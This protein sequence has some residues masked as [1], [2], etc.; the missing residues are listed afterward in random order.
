MSTRA[1][2]HT[3]D[4]NSVFEALLLALLAEDFFAAAFFA[5]AADFFAVAIASPGGGIE[6][7]RRWGIRGERDQT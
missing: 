4:F 3:K 7:A 2:R 5:P 6:R 1:A